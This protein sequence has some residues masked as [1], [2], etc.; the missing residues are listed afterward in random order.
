[1]EKEVKAVKDHD[2][3]GKSL[4]Q[5]SRILMGVGIIISAVL[6][7][8][9]VRDA[10]ENL[11]YASVITMVG[12][13]ILCKLLEAAGHG[14]ILMHE[15]NENSKRM[16]DMLEKQG[17]AKLMNQMTPISAAESVPMEA[18]PVIG[19]EEDQIGIDTFIAELQKTF[20]NE[21]TED[22]SYS[23]VKDCTE[24]KRVVITKEVE[25]LASKINYI[26]ENYMD[27][28]QKYKKIQQDLAHSV[29]GQLESCGLNDW[30]VLFQVT[31]SAI[32]QQ[33]L[34]IYQN[35]IVYDFLNE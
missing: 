26:G 22:T 21:S 30:N 1:M 8:V 19:D 31:D 15:Q 28:W 25:R 2:K 6:I 23:I 10:H 4:V 27:S 13:I 29:S 11:L 34:S 3:Y 18:E 14:I 16:I 33:M 17:Q 12:S 20:R 32:D 5:L 9:S 35:E 24:E 7:I